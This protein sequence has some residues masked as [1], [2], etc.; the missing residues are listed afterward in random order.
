MRNSFCHH[1]H[2]LNY[3]FRHL[4]HH[5]EVLFAEVLE[6]FVAQEADDHA[7][8]LCATLKV[9]MHFGKQD[10]RA[11]IHR[12][13]KDPGGDRGQSDRFQAVAVRQGEGRTHRGG[14]FAILVAF[15]LAR[16][17]GMDHSFR[18]QFAGP[19]HH[20]RTHGRAA[21]S[22]AFPL[23]RL[24]TFLQNGTCNARAQ[25]EILVGGVDQGIDLELCNITLHE[26][27]ESVIHLESNPVLV[28]RGLF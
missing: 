13:A 9:A 10:A 15:A 5:H 16:T 7:I 24:A 14:E 19:G 21:D 20:R 11:T 1:K 8:E 4:R 27:E 23:Y 25:N 2:V 28:H 17:D 12:E 6:D 26:L 18:Q 22:V 3:F